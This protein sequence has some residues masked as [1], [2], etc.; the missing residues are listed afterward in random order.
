MNPIHSVALLEQL[1]LS[2]VFKTSQQDKL[3]S[4]LRYED[5]KNKVLR[6]SRCHKYR[7]VSYYSRNAVS[8]GGIIYSCR[9]YYCELELD[10][11]LVVA[12]TN[13]SQTRAK[14]MVIKWKGDVV[15]SIIEL[16]CYN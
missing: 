13:V 3:K 8:H 2:V 5:W 1:A 6:C 7:P 12:Q 15:E 16:V 4:D 11:E 14:E 9:C 10:V